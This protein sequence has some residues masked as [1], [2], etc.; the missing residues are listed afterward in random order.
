[1]T[2]TQTICGWWIDSEA[3]ERAESQE[4]LPEKSWPVEG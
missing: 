2:A 1:M 4:E 3:A